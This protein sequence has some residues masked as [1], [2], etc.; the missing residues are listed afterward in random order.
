MN[1]WGN[2][3]LFDF[4]GTLVSGEM[5]LG[6]W[7]SPQ[8]FEDLLHPLGYTEHTREAAGREGSAF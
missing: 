4:R 5:S 2:L 1:A 8:N 7:N 6:L 3:P